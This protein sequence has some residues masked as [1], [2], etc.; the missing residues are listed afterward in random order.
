MFAT[1]DASIICIKVCARSLIVILLVTFFSA[2]ALTTITTT[3]I[4]A[5]TAHATT[6]TTTHPQLHDQCAGIQSY[7]SKLKCSS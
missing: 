5:T 2:T 3:T 1:A 7:R 6:K 4:A